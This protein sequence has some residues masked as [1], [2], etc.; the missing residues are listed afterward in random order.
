[1]HDLNLPVSLVHDVKPEPAPQPFQ[2]AERF[3]VEEIVSLDLIRTHTKTDDIPHV[4][5]EQLVLY[6]RAAIEAAEQYSGLLLQKQRRV[7]EPFLNPPKRSH[8]MRQM[9]RH[10][11]EYATAQD[12]VFVYG[13][14]V[15]ER[16]PVKIGS[17]VIYLPNV[18]HAID[19]SFACC[20]PCGNG[21]MKTGF[22]IMYMAGYDCVNSIPAGIIAGVLKYI[23]WMIE[24]PGDVYKPVDN[25]ERSNATFLQGTNNVAWASGALELWR[26]YNKDV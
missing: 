7:E 12:H 21:G 9:F 11:L 3:A 6:A 24:N 20:S 8:D 10:R 4:T 16:V 25:R 14:G 17:K 1:M 23:A 2:D 18:F 26:Q 15:S 13:P 22:R 5:D 19:F